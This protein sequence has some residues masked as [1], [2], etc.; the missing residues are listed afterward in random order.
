MTW[1][2]TLLAAVED[3][4]AIVK[5]WR[6]RRDA[7]SE[8]HEPTYIA[9]SNLE[10][11]P[12]ELRLYIEGRDALGRLLREYVELDG[13]SLHQLNFRHG[14]KRGGLSVSSWLSQQILEALLRL[15]VRLDMVRE[16]KE[17]P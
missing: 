11:A 12:P 17:A 7:M 5:G 14:A 3:P 6:A 10:P 16:Q 15:V 2:R 4:W 9:Y 1:L 13:Y 8:H